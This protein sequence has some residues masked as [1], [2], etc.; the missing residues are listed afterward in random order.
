MSRPS[1]VIVPAA[2]ALP[3][4]YDTIV[5]RVSQHGYDIKALH[6]PSVGLVTGARP[7]EPPTMYDDAAFIAAYVKGLA[8][9]GR[10]VLLVTHSYGGTAATQSVRGLSKSERLKEGKTG[11]IVGLAYMT[12]LVPEVGHPASALAGTAP[13]GQEPLMKVGDDG[14]FYYPNLIL[15]AKVVF[16]DI[17]LEEG[18]YWARKLV[19]H[20]AASF[21]SKL[22][23]AGYNDVPV[24]YLVAEDDQSI[25]PATQKSQ[26]EMIERTSGNKVDVSSVNSGHVPPV[27]HPQHVIDWVLSVAQKFT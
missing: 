22:T 10:D 25:A 6:I 20:S 16:S 17:S 12:S 4:F 27:S 8:D 26:I 13:E 5:D 23:Y 1:I 18:K 3:L 7:G 21:A 9:A 11:G 24:S 14:W 15:T 2:S 19:K